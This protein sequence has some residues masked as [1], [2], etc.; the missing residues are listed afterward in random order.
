LTAAAAAVVGTMAKI[1]L[2]L[3]AMTCGHCVQ[4]VTAAARGVD[5]DARVDVDLPQRRVMIESAQPRAAFVAALVEAG[6]APA[7]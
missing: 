1:E 7:A 5:P 6:Y 2:T 4:A 3:P